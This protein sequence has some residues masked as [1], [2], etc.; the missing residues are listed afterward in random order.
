MSEPVI[1]EGL[2]PLD[3]FRAQSVAKAIPLQA[4]LELTY[5]CNERC[6]HCYIEEFK[7]DPQRKL[8]KEQWF[9]V[10]DELRSA[11]TLYVILMGGE[12]MLNPLFWDVAEYASSLNFHVSMISNGLKIQKLE[13]AQRLKDCGVQVVTFSLYSMDPAIHDKMTSVRGSL[14]KTLN[15]IELCDQV[16]IVPGINVLLT[17][18]NARG[19]FEIY[20]WCEEK[21]FEC[22]VDPT[23]TPK[24][25]GNLD[26]TKYRA[27]K[28]TNPP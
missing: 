26:P 7:D 23:V 15:A 6:T 27:T 1:R 4:S 9:K 25:N 19:I 11:G 24:L 22:K 18:A 2:S 21:N 20:D 10:L 14:D 17:E 5:R 8:T 28:E 13:V 3:R 16:G 12:A